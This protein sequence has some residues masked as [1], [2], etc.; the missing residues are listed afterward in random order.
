MEG[1]SH[2]DPNR[3]QHG[4]PHAHD[5]RRPPLLHLL[6][7]RLRSSLPQI[8]RQSRSRYPR[9]LRNRRRPPRS[10]S[11]QAPP[12]RSPAR[13]TQPNHPRLPP[14][15]P[16]L[17]LLR[18]RR[19]RNH[20]P[21]QARSPPRRHRTPRRI[22]RHQARKIRH[23]LLR[24]HLRT[25]GRLLPPQ[26]RRRLRK[27]GHSNR[28]APRPPRL[29]RRR[30]RQTQNRAPLQS[31][32]WRRLPPLRIF[33]P[34]APPRCPR[35]L[36]RP[37]PPQHP[38][39]SPQNPCRHARCYLLRRLHPR[40]SLPRLF[41]HLQIQIPP[42]TRSQHPRLQ[43]RCPPQRH[44]PRSSRPRPP[45]THRPQLPQSRLDLL[46]RPRPPRRPRHLG[47]L[48]ERIPRHRIPRLLWLHPPLPPKSHRK[49]LSIFRRLWLRAPHVRLRR[50]ML[51]TP[52]PPR[53]HQPRPR[54]HRRSLP[55][56]PLRRRLALSHK[57]SRDFVYICNGGPSVRRFPPLLRHRRPQ[58]NR[59]LG[60]FH[61]A[62][63]SREN[64]RR[65][66]RPHAQGQ[67]LRPI[68]P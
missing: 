47:S 60:R 16:R 26:R 57:V 4:R 50:R 10:R 14:H 11:R 44:R 61:R 43:S 31:H 3:A 48:Q 40:R 7:P 15:G 9:R 62:Q 21:P 66:P 24:L 45:R 59:H 33:R 64:R 22:P 68:P 55:P 35:P 36:A 23:L 29:D 53:H 5:R 49:P 38:P 8:P 18:R 34:Q 42:R 37:R 32:E 12:P 51:R 52:R 1:M 30:I 6:S 63:R 67:G 65:Y 39:Q 20:R 46:R 28:R 2:L 27:D 56:P 19:P 17:R 58:R 25:L 41:R 13:Q 54:L